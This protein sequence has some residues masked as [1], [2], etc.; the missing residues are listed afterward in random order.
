MLTAL[1]AVGHAAQTIHITEVGVTCGYNLR[2]KL[3]SLRAR[4]TVG[5]GYSAFG[6]PPIYRYHFQNGFAYASD[7]G[8]AGGL[9]GNNPAEFG[10]PLSFASGTAAR[11]VQ[12]RNAAYKSA[13]FTS[14]SNL[15]DFT[16][17]MAQCPVHKPLIVSH[18]THIVVRGVG[19]MEATKATWSW[20]MSAPARETTGVRQ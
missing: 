15:F 4:V 19:Q 17:L 18:A 7:Y 8:F 11:T 1:P 12:I 14:W 20:T 13:P 3:V 6:S 9:P 2:G 5:P 10:L 16:P